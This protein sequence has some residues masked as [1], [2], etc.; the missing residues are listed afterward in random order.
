M[1]TPLKKMQ[2][3]LDFLIKKDFSKNLSISSSFEENKGFYNKKYILFSEKIKVITNLS[4]FAIW[5]SF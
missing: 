2:P 4:P 3:D 1:G 5:S